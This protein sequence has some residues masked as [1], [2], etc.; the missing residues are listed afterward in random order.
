MRSSSSQSVDV[1]RTGDVEELEG[2]ADEENDLLLVVLGQ[3]R[4][5]KTGSTRYGADWEEH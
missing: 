3:G 1:V 2:R 5:A 4:R